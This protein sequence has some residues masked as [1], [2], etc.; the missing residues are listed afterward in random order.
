MTAV[1]AI[2]ICVK[3]KYDDKSL[4][5]KKYSYLLFKSKFQMSINNSTRVEINTMYKFC[6]HF[7]LKYLYRRPS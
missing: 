7:N 1:T 5:A 6:Q 4:L 3:F 2:G